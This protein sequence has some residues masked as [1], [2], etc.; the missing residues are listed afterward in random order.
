MLPQGIRCIDYAGARHVRALGGR[1]VL[2]R[3]RDHGRAGHGQVDEDEGGDDAC[4][5]HSEMD[6]GPRVR[7]GVRRGEASQAKPRGVRSPLLLSAC[8]PTKGIYLSICTPGGGRG[9][10]LSSTTYVRPL[11]A[12]W[13]AAWPT[14][15][16]IDEPDDMVGVDPRMPILPHLPRRWP[17][18]L[19]RLDVHLSTSPYTRAYLPYL[20]L[21]LP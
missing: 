17:V 21:P 7:D 2:G 15:R 18:C 3:T 8:V 19:F 4:R 9:G 14:G 16:F 13:L 12:S 1:F 10:G 6:L 5:W 11:L 20:L